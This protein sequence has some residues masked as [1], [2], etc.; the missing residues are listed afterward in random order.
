[1]AKKEDTFNQSET[2]E[3]NSLWSENNL[4]NLKEWIQIPI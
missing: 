1:M 2:W 4:G 3:E